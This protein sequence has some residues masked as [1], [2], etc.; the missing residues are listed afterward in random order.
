MRLMAKAMDLLEHLD[1]IDALRAFIV[2][3][4]GLALILAGSVTPIV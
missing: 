3:G 2:S 4:C 1:L